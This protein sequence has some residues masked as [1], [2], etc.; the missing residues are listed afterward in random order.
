ML[1]KKTQIISLDKEIEGKKPM[2]PNSVAISKNGDIYW[3]D[4]TADFTLEDGVY[5]LL[6]DA[7]GRY[8]ETLQFWI[9]NVVEI[10]YLHF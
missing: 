6:A 4:S 10:I 5:T 1:G 7:S 2:L 8:K 9:F 3:T